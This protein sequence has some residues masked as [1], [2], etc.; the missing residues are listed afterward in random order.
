MDLDIRKNIY[1]NFKDSNSKELRE[2]IE[3]SIDKDEIVLPGM[4]VLF[5]IMWKNANKDF[6]EEVLKLI[7]KGLFW[8]EPHFGHFNKKDF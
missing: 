7:E 8:S 3:A 2:S 6:Q 4:G 5:E 1:N